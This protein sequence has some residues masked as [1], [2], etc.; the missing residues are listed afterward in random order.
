MGR[1]LAL[2]SGRRSVFTLVGVGLMVLVGLAM[3]Q[4]ASAAKW[5]TQFVPHSGQDVLNGVSCVSKTECI[6]VGDGYGGFGASFV[7]Q[8]NGSRWSLQQTSAAELNGVSCLSATACMAVGGYSA[9]WWDGTRWSGVP[10]PMKPN[11]ELDAV[12]CSSATACT[13][14]GRKGLTGTGGVE[15][16]KSYAVQWNGSRWSKEPVPHAGHPVRKD[17]IQLL[18]A[19]SCSSATACTAVGNYQNFN[20]NARTLAERWNGR[21]WSPQRTPQYGTA[22]NWRSPWL[23]FGGVSCPSAKE[24]IAVGSY[25]TNGGPGSRVIAARWSNGRW[26]PQQIPNPGRFNLCSSNFPCPSVSCPSARLCIAVGSY[27]VRHGEE[28]FAERWNGSRWSRLRTPNLPSRD[29]PTFY[30]LSCT[31]ATACVAVGYIYKQGNPVP[32]VERYS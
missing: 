30:G 32:L 9:E 22:P 10:T 14:V 15:Q 26:S 23:A 31:S 5:R 21:K 20:L 8:W 13:A 29:Q 6:A 18:T 17:D 16:G 11:S 19:V 3:A 4:T 25:T 12:S 28:M 27:I 7:E 1:G 2:R 24:C